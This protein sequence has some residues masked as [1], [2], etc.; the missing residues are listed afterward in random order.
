VP[1]IGPAI[2]WIVVLLL[3]SSYVAAWV[4]HVRVPYTV[5][6]VITGIIL[7]TAGVL[8]PTTFSPD[9]V[10][11]VLLPPLIF[12]AAFAIE[13]EGLR[14]S[15][16]ALAGMA[17]MGVVLSAL[18]TAALGIWLVGLS[19]GDAAIFGVLVA[20]TDPVS[21]IAFFREANVH[22]DLRALVEGESLLNDGTVVVLVGVVA[23]AV[24]LGQISVLG[25]IGQFLW[26]SAGGLVVGA[27]VGLAGAIVTPRRDDYLLEATISVAVAY[28]S[29]LLA[30][31]IGLSGILATVAA[32]SVLGNAASH[33]GLSASTRESIEKLWDFLAFVANSFVFLL[34]GIAVAPATLLHLLPVIAVG[35][36]AAMAGR[37]ACV[38]VVGGLAFRISGVPTLRWR[39]VLVVGGLRGALPVV[40]ARSLGTGDSGS[41]LGSAIPIEDLVLGVV[42]VTLIVQGLALKPAVGWLLRPAR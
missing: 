25:A 24:G 5:G 21:I 22:R 6:L 7:D 20:A 1:S 4:G 3:L 42:V 9:L 13:W 23:A 40:L 36:V 30:Q 16:V 12:E 41:L 32:G 26:L 15:A 11:L 31:E 38:Y 27:A 8:P 37:I 35:V 19:V 10:L 33:R 2:E 14:R 29:Y 39:H 34:L 28:G 17:T 18:L